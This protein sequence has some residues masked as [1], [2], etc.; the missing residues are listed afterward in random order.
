MAV[1]S[2]IGRRTRSKGDSH[3]VDKKIKVSDYMTRDIVTFRPDQYLVEVIQ[4]LLQKNI[5][6]GPVVDDENKLVGIISEGDCLKEISDC[7][8]HNYPMENIKVKDHMI[9]RVETIDGDMNVLD[10]ANKFLE[11]RHRR[12]PIVENGKLVG[13]ISQRDVLNAAMRLKEQKIDW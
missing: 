5:S 2:F 6:G 11:T 10:A 13:L 7:R 4:T 12:F 1:K 8:Y 3:S 9:K